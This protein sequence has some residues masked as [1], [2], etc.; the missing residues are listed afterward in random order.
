MNSF[1]LSLVWLT[2]G[3]G[4]GSGSMEQDMSHLPSQD[5]LG[6]N[7]KRVKYQESSEKGKK[8]E[9]AE[10]FVETGGRSGK[11]YHQAQCTPESGSGKTRSISLTTSHDDGRG[12]EWN[13]I[14]WDDG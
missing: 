13:N 7:T 2:V 3:V 5:F 12:M 10:L 8:K 6:G 9:K 14:R 1:V 11:K 4:N